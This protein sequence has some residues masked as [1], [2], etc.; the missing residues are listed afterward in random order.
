MD[1]AGDISSRISSVVESGG[2]PRYTRAGFKD[3]NPRAPFSKSGMIPSFVNP[4]SFLSREDLHTDESDG[5][6]ASVVVNGMQNAHRRVLLVLPSPHDAS[7]SAR[8]SSPVVVYPVQ[9]AHVKKTVILPVTDIRIKGFV[10]GCIDGVIQV[11][12]AQQP[13]AFAPLRVSS[14]Q[15]WAPAGRLALHLAFAQ[16]KLSRPLH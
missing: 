9:A 2:A 3:P 6:D 1:L 12:S 8:W 15:H 11:P 5:S 10:R 7:G 16:L 4:K 14:Q 13:V